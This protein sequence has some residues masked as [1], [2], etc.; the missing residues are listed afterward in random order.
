MRALLT[1]ATIAGTL[2]ASPAA[3]ANEQLKQQAD[4]I[5]S[6]SFDAA[7]P[8]ASAIIT[9][10]G[11]TIY[12]GSAGL[13]DIEA[14][15]HARPDTVYYLGSVSKQYTAAVI[16]QLA[17][18]GKLSLS[19]PLSKFLPDYPEPGREATV[20]QLLNHTAG[21]PNYANI[22]GWMSEPNINRP[23]TT[24]QLIA[25]FKGLPQEDKPGEDWEYSNSGYVLLGAIIEKVTGKP[26]QQ[27]VRDRILRPLALNETLTSLPKGGVP[28]MAKGY[29][30]IN[31]KLG[32]PM[33]FD[34]SIGGAGGGLIG[35]ASDLAKWSDALHHGRVVPGP[36]YQQMITPAKLN[37][38]RS[39]PYGFGLKFAKLH[40]EQVIGHGG[41]IPGFSTFGL[42]LPKEDLFVAVLTN[43]DAPR[44]A[45]ED[46]ATRLAALA[47]GRPFPMLTE[48]KADPAALQKLF[49]LY[50]EGMDQHRLFSRDGKF[51]LRTGNQPAH[52][53]HFAGDNRFYYDLVWLQVR[54]QPSGILTMEIHVPT[55]TAAAVLPRTGSAPEERA[56][57]NV[58]VEVLRSYTGVYKAGAGTG[59]IML[60]DGK[61]LVL[62][63]GKD[64]AT[65]LR[66]VSNIEFLDD[67]ENSSVIFKT[68]RGKTTGL[69]VKRGD[70]DVEAERIGDLMASPPSASPDAR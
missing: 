11:K 68:A 28:G 70:H 25:V 48:T 27:A 35:T 65:R 52:E 29:S 46:V 18:E 67:D 50:G 15:R 19:D 33:K 38:G 60:V 14:R 30:L 17:S 56:T 64:A 37:D 8:G 20:A 39:F 41:R 57:V 24:Q 43:S 34:L 59:K 4:A 21:I 42:Y 23:Y 62:Q 47:A 40:D 13:A 45:P 55:L 53:V 10:H 66:P 22:T 5:L 51:Y 9:E 31:D 12:A 16:L 26:W 3:A 69:T 32:P 44:T 7:G 49:G 2:I 36:Y 63:H 58:P 1:I 54:P 61:Y 6:S